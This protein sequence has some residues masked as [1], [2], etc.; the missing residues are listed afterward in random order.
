VKNRDVETAARAIRPL[1]RAET[2][3]LTCQNGVSAWERLGAIVGML[4][5]VLG[6]ARNPAE[7]GT[8]RACFML[9]Q[10]PDDLLFASNCSLH[11]PPFPWG[12]L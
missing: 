8:L 2:M 9:L 10:D 3:I 4:R 5:V 6:F 7:I 12:G 1:I 11:C